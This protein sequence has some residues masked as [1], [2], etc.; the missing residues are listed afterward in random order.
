MPPDFLVQVVPLR[1]L[2]MVV[3]DGMLITTEPGIA[4]I[5]MNEPLL[6][7][8]KGMYVGHNSLEF[9]SSPFQNKIKIVYFKVM[10]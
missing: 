5:Q 6:N 1:L 4:K 3:K 8:C 9:G 10:I 7:A 2:L